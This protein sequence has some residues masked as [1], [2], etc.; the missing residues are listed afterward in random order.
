MV[1][2]AARG[3]ALPKVGAFIAR[4]GTSNEEGHGVIGVM[5][6]FLPLIAG[7]K[8][9]VTITHAHKHREI[10]IFPSV[11][12]TVVSQASFP[13]EELRSPSGTVRLA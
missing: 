9:E 5:Q 3:G 12:T 2:V 8:G 6:P 13:C 1:H 4:E 7:F 10:I 11:Y